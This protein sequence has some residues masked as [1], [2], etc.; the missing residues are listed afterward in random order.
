MLSLLD[1][2]AVPTSIESHSWG[3]SL[4][5]ATIEMDLIEGLALQLLLPFADETVFESLLTGLDLIEVFELQM[6]V[7]DSNTGWL[8]GLRFHARLKGGRSTVCPAR[9]WLQSARN[10]MR[11]SRT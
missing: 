11:P 5:V 1:S 2:H 9:A 3:A 8:E 6:Q 7:Q 4:W 10:W